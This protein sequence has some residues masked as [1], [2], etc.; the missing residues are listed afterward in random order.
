M[1][2]MASLINLGKEKK[3]NIF[4]YILIPLVCTL[5]LAIL[6][7]V[8]FLSS[9]NQ[10]LSDNLYG[11][12]NALDAIVIVAI[13]DKSLQEV[14]RWPWERDKFVPLIERLSAAKVIAMD[15]AFFEPYKP[16]Q[17]ALLGKAIVDQKVIIPLEFTSFETVYDTDGRKKVVG[18]D[19]LIPISEMSGT[20]AGYVNI[21]TDKDGI[22]RAINM[23]I[24]EEFENFAYLAY[25][26]FWKKDIYDEMQGR[27]ILSRFLVN[28]VGPPRSFKYYPASEVINGNYDLEEFKGKLVL[29]GA[30]APDLHDDYFVPVSYG[31]AMPGVEIHANAIQTMI[32]RDLLAEQ[33]YWSVII[34]MLF[35]SLALC[36]VFYKF[37]LRGALAAAAV[38]I[39]AYLSLV[40]ILFEKGI[41]MNVI[42]FPLAVLLT[43][44]AEVTMFYLRERKAKAELKKAFSKYVSPV[45]VEELM[46]NPDKLKLGG[47][48][49]EIT[50]FFSDIRGF[51]SISEKLSPEDLVKL[52]NEYLSEMTNIVMEKRGTVDKFIG[53]A[54]MAFWGAPLVEKKH[55]EQ[56]CEA[57]LLM[58]DRLAE[59]REKWK[60]EGRPEINIGIGLNTGPAIIGNMGSL[61]RFDYTAMGDT[62]NLGSRLEGLTKQYGVQAIISESTEA[63][64]SDKFVVR[65]LDKVAVKGKKEPIMIYELV[66]RKGKVSEQK[67][68]LIRDYEAGLKDYFA[69]RWDAAGGRF[70]RCESDMAA[71]MFSERCEMYAKDAPPA[72]WDGTW[73]MKTK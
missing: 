20:K 67:L 62:I 2:L 61:E 47:E 50:I 58:L 39:G 40:I 38:L 12:K 43:G 53:D 69:R 32:N 24:S 22:T 8:G 41:I 59:L 65:K 14:G 44:G 7:Q 23:D 73:V 27:E 72:E 21:V 51:T 55:A 42:Y 70:A 1:F 46:K 15:V 63:K 28:F 49:R 10:K 11:G 60:S 30:T 52:L 71:K 25:K 35:G 18:K 66:G 57:S 5:I 45:V 37:K 56:A 31:K 4:Y 36:L 48:R 54:V 17:D 19:K 9:V 34:G 29:I 13:D 68:K 16:E 33:S 26:E 64:I 3:E 6:F